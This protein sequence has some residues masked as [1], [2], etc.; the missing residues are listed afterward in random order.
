MRKEILQLLEKNS[1][2][3]PAEIAVMIGSDEETVANE[4]KAMENEN[5]I[6]G[7]HALVDWDKVE[8]ERV[9]A[10]IGLKI[11]PVRGEGFDRIS[12]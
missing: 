2:L 10:L 6:C 4:I 11:S 9:T 3:T 12:M 1:R 7:Y 5:I 8:N